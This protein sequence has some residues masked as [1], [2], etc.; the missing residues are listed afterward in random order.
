MSNQTNEILFSRAYEVKSYFEGTDLE[1]A[2]NKAIEDN[3]LERLEYMVVEAE[4]E[5]SRENFF[6]RNLIGENDVY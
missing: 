6:T 1:R 3:D 5:M 2:I 4:E